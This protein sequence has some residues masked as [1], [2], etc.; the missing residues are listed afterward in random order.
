[1][2]RPVTQGCLPPAFLGPSQNS[3]LAGLPAGPSTSL[4][5]Q[6]QAG[7][8]RVWVSEAGVR[9]TL[10]SVSPGDGAPAVAAGLCWS[11]GKGVG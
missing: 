5:C 1:M 8:G 10:L 7:A 4:V 9:A 2:G 11:F 3:S 6:E